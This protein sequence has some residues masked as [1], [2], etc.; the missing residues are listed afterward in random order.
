MTGWPAGL[1]QDDCRELSLWFASK[2]DAR[3]IVREV[4]KEIKM[5]DQTWNKSS[6]KPTR[7]D[8]YER[9]YSRTTMFAKYE[10]GF[11][12]SPCETVEKAREETLLA[13]VSRQWRELNA[14][15]TASV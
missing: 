15:N 2:P 12:F 10:D 14:T 8:V 5:T 9:K 3:R 1:M 4:I 13:V 6:V 7:N 11:W